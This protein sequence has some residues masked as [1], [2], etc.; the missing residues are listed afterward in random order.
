MLRNENR[1]EFRRL[2]RPLELDV[3][4]FIYLLDYLLDD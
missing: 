3:W 4:L 1:A 2:L